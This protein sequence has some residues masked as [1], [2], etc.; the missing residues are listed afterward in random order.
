MTATVTLVVLCTLHNYMISNC[1]PPE[2]L[3]M[4]VMMCEL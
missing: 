3:P 4:E 1:V 2:L